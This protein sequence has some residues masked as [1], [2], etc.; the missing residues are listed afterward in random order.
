MKTRDSS[1]QL[2]VVAFIILIAAISRILPHPANVTPIGA[3]ALFGGTYFSRKYLA[4]LIPIIA[5]LV[6]DI[7]L[8]NTILRVFFPDHVGIVLFSKYMIWTYIGFIAVVGVGIVFLKKVSTPRLLSGSLI[9]SSLFFLISNFGAWLQFPMYPKNF[10][11]LLSAYAAALPFF[12]T[13]ILGDLFFVAVLFGSFYLI[14][15]TVFQKQLA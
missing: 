1:K 4:F 10:S 9:G 5:L 8:N 15:K 14:R 6:S 3:M 11:G 2:F 12:R 7:I 13:S